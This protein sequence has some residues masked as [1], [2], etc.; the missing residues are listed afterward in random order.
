MYHNVA[1]GGHLGGNKMYSRL[2]QTFF[3]FWPH[4]GDDRKAYSRG[5]TMCGSRKPPQPK[6]Q[7]KMVEQEVAGPWERIAIDVLSGFNTSKNGNKL[8]LVVMDEFTKWPEVIALKDQKAS[9]IARALVNEA[10][11]DMDYHE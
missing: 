1:H 5:C 8:L 7:G 3:K 10:F 2:Q 6:S 9:T 11:T 4:M